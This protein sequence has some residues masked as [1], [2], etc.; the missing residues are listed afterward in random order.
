MLS[1]ACQGTDRLRQVSDTP[2]A[3]SPSL[4][5]LLS[6]AP[7]HHAWNY[8]SR[9]DIDC[10]V[11]RSA[12]RL[13]VFATDSTWRQHCTCLIL[14]HV[15]PACL[16]G[17]TL[18]PAALPR[19]AGSAVMEATCRVIVRRGELLLSGYRLS[20]CSVPVSVFK[21]VNTVVHEDDIE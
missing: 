20:F 7:R 18:C 13:H 3:S 17:V 11:I 12:T 1:K 10:L 8:G 6:P 21:D 19:C 9:L 4:I 15:S 14:F 2:V 5:V 16:P